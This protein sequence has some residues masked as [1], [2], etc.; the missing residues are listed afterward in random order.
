MCDHKGHWCGASAI[1]PDHIK[2]FVICELC[3]EKMRSILDQPYKVE[4][5]LDVNQT[6][7]SES[8][9]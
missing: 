8:P 3:G 5:K 2:H 9:A 6:R 7:T 4:A 1:Y